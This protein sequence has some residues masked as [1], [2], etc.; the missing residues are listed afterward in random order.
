VR[1]RRVVVAADHLVDDPDPEVSPALEPLVAGLACQL[2][3]AL[4]VL[5]LGRILGT[6]LREELRVENAAPLLEQPR[7][8]PHQ[9]QARSLPRLGGSA[10]E[11][12]LVEEVGPLERIVGQL[13]RLGPASPAAK[14]SDLH[15]D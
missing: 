13:E 12:L 1:Q 7:L 3:R 11:R 4:E 2:E 10:E 8:R 9:L 14:L 15:S 6:P 5:Q